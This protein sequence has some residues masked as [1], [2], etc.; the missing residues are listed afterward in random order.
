MMSLVKLF[1]HCHLKCVVTKLM[2]LYMVSALI[3]LFRFPGYYWLLLSVSLVTV[4]AHA[5]AR[6]HMGY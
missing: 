2:C 6:I 5:L 4:S 1:S 3:R